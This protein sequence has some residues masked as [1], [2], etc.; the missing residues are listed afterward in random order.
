MTVTDS[1][2]PRDILRALYATA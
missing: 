2:G 1:T